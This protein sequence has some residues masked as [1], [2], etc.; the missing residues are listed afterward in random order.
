MVT[1][2]SLFL[3]PLLQATPTALAWGRAPL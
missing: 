3:L 1:D 2:G